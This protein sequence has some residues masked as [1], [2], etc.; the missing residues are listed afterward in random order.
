MDGVM[1]N[2]TWSEWVLVTQT[3]ATDTCT[4]CG[5]WGNHGYDDEGRELVCYACNGTG[6]FN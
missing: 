2:L 3:E 6:G 5:G 4:S 1:N